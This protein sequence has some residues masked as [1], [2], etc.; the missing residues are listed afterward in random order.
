MRKIDGL[1]LVLLAIM[2]GAYAFIASHISWTAQMYRAVHAGFLYML[3]AT[4]ITVV[5]ALI[6]LSAAIVLLRHGRNSFSVMLD[7]ADRRRLGVLAALVA[8]YWYICPVLLS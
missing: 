4:I 6:A 2:G 7:F 8:G 5:P 3:P 1:L